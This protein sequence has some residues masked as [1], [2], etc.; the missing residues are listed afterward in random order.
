MQMRLGLVV[1]IGLLLSACGAPKVQVQPTLPPVPTYSA[2]PLRIAGYT[3]HIPPGPARN[4]F[5][6]AAALTP[7]GLVWSSYRSAVLREGQ[8]VMPHP[9]R[10]HLSPGGR[11]GSLEHSGR[12]I[13]RIPQNYAGQSVDL[14]FNGATGPYLAF[15]LSQASSQATL[16]TGVVGLVSGRVSMV[17]PVDARG[18]EVVA[19]GDRV[20][21][22]QKA[23]VVLYNP[24][25]GR[26]RT[27]PAVDGQTLGSDLAY[28]LPP[29]SHTALGHALRGVVAYPL[30]HGLVIY[31]PPG[32]KLSETDTGGDWVLWQVTDPADPHRY[33]QETTSACWGC[34]SIGS[35]LVPGALDSPGPAKPPTSH[36]VSDFAIESR[37]SLKGSPYPIL[38]MWISPMPGSYGGRNTI[39]VSLP[40]SQA[41]LA[42]RILESFGVPR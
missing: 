16:A 15:T 29:G 12:V 36:W 11:H 2:Q 10:I 34:S 5:K 14:A 38:S 17:R 22:I 4:T 42:R 33:V 20:G 9:Y 18:A 25:T 30:G 27:L 6:V 21:L 40:A 8:D 32:W 13:A 35:G 3:A 7:Y 28:G 39:E 19:A 41:A 24:A 26:Y 1:A 31:G 37:Y 23:K